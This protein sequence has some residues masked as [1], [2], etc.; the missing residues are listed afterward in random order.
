MVLNARDTEN[1][2]IL[3]DLLASIIATPAVQPNPR[4]ENYFDINVQVDE[5]SNDYD[6]DQMVE[7]VKQKIYDDSMYRNVNSLGLLR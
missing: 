7:R 4:N 5:I 1:F 3:K 6:V 2:I